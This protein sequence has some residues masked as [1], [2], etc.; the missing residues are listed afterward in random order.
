MLVASSKNPFSCMFFMAPDCT[1]H[2]VRGTEPNLLWLVPVS[3]FVPE[4]GNVDVGRFSRY[5]AGHG[6]IPLSS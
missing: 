2:G 1:E 3:G 6:N 5:Y 4:C